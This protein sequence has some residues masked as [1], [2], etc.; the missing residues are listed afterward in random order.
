MA[1][2]AASPFSEGDTCVRQTG[3]L[4][5]VT[6][7]TRLLHLI[8]YNMIDRRDGSIALVFTILAGNVSGILRLIH[9][10]DHG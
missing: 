8:A 5:T 4:F 7:S 6:R 10:S 1:N 3:A 2:K 9:D